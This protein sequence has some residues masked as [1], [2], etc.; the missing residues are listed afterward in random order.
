MTDREWTAWRVWLHP[1]MA[2]D[3]LIDSEIME[4]EYIRRLLSAEEKIRVMDSAKEDKDVVIEEHRKECERLQAE[5]EQLSVEV[6]RLAQRCAES[7]KAHA[8]TRRQLEEALSELTEYE[9]I[10]RR[11]EEFGKMLDKVEEMKRNYEK[12]IKDLQSRLREARAAK[13]SESENE[14]FEEPK[15]D[16]DDWLMQLPSDL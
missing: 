7:E 3:A 14:L 4:N 6:G 15:D 10:D 5:K 2:L 8:A 9:D 16:S 13:V 12:R 1:R 11:F